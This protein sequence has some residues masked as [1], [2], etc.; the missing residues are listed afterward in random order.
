MGLSAVGV[1]T[2][3]A[4]MLSPQVEILISDSEHSGVGASNKSGASG[5]SDD[6]DDSDFEE[7]SCG[8]SR[9]RTRGVLGKSK[10]PP[11]K[12]K[13]KKMAA[14]S[15]HSNGTGSSSRETEAAHSESGLEVDATDGGSGRTEGASRS[16][17]TLGEREPIAGSSSSAAAFSASSFDLEE[18]SKRRS[19][20]QA[21]LKAAL[22]DDGTASVAAAG[23]GGT[24]GDAN[25]KEG[26]TDAGAANAER[27]S[28]MP[29]SRGK[30]KGAAAGRVKLTPMEQQV[31]DLKEK[32]PGVLLL[33]ECGYRYRFFGEDA[34]TA[35]KVRFPSSLMRAIGV[36]VSAPTCSRQYFVSQKV[37]VLTCVC[38]TTMFC[39]AFPA[40]LHHCE[41]GLSCHY[42]C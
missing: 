31:V 11:A 10:E 40:S 15:P 20:F 5:D 24:N 39:M 6:D 42:S 32:H 34:L 9:K 35:A 36:C 38:C 27:P 41:I 2:P 29:S 21:G 19:D 22:G 25:A 28:G 8:P 13:N 3:A 14:N 37:V 7:K 26:G 23:G 18:N 12:G 16:I 30:G 17:L 4:L 1:T 33:V